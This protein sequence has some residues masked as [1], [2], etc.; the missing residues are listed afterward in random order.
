MPLQ[1]IA[2]LEL[3]A[4]QSKEEIKKRCAEQETLT[5]RL[6]EATQVSGQGGPGPRGHGWARGSRSARPHSSRLPRFQAEGQLKQET[7]RRGQ[8]VQELGRRERLLRAE[9]EQAATQVGQV[10]PPPL[11][12]RAQG[13]PCPSA[14][15][16]PSFLGPSFR[17]RAELRGMGVCVGGSGGGVSPP[18]LELCCPQAQRF[19]DQV[20]RALFPELPEK[21]LTDEQVTASGWGGTPV[22]SVSP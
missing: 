1:R 17:L 8:Q 14:L 20:V 2:E 7:Q 18:A 12:P 9:M 22:W 16:H 13:A 15:S 5:R 19:R 6:A 11:F 3:Q 10:L 4:G 21:P